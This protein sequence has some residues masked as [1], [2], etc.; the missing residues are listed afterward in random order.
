[1]RC[2]LC[3]LI[4]QHERSVYSHLGIVV[5][6]SP[7]V[8]VAESQGSV[9]LTPLADFLRQADPTREQMILR[10]KER[11][12]LPL[13]EAIQAWIGADY[14]HDFRWDNLGRDGRE[15]LYCSELVTKLL[16][17][18]LLNKI[19]TKLMDYSENHA[20]WESYFR[21]D[22]PQDL[23]G[24]SPGD[25]ER[26]LLFDKIGTVQGNTWNWN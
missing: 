19:P 20:A 23:P 10:L 3:R 13:K 1:M 26:S 17:P 24:N 9:K 22:I 25:F 21:G 4:E 5:L 16:N 8:L 12:D 6:S 15:A 18:Y 14:D 7:E 11:A 2:Y